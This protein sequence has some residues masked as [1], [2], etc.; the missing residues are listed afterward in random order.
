MF[1]LASDRVNKHDFYTLM[2]LVCANSCLSL[3]H[4]HANVSGQIEELIPAEQSYQSY[5]KPRVYF[6]H[7]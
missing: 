3:K 7:C 2:Q 5:S 4:D 1:L 6:V